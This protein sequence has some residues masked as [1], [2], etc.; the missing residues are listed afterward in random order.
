MSG[1][2]L[3]YVY[4]QVLDALDDNPKVWGVS[5]LRREFSKHLRH[6][7]EALK[8]VEWVE[9]GDGSEAEEDAAIRKVL[10]LKQRDDS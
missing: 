4:Q 8:A 2:K 6:V 5:I 7:A 1:G 9:S 3:R 10:G